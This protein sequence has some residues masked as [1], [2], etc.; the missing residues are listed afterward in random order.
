MGDGNGDDLDL[1]MPHNALMKSLPDENT[2]TALAAIDTPEPI[3][4][5]DTAN[6]IQNAIAFYSEIVQQG[7]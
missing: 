3:L 6:N 2:A 7:G 4:S 1:D 5:L